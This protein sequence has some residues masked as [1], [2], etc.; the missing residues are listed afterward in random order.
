MSQEMSQKDQ[1]QALTPVP[2]RPPTPA[3]PNPQLTPAEPSE[4]LGRHKNTG[5]KHHKATRNQPLHDGSQRSAV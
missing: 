2:G 5:Q 1:R 4:V 3:A